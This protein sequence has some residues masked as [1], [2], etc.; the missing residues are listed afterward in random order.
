ML[1]KT[2]TSFPLFLFS[3]PKQTCV[4]EFYVLSNIHQLWIAFYFSF[5]FFFLFELGSIEPS[6]GQDT[7]KY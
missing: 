1:A 2:D 4:D 6:M 5:L 7:A 3:L